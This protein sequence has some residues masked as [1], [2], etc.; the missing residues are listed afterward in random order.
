MRRFAHLLL[1]MIL[2]PPLAA[3]EPIR[4]GCAAPAGDRRDV[5]ADRGLPTQWRGGAW[6]AAGSSFY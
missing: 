1:P 4:S 5:D 2:Y 3:V 6:K